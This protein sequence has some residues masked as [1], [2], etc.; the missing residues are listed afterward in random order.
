MKKIILIALFLSMGISS[1]AT[2]IIGGE[3]SYKCLG[4]NLY[5]YT[6]KI[7][8]DCFNGVPPL[9]DPAYFTIFD[10][11]GNV[12]LNTPVTLL[13]DSILPVNSPSPCL[14]IPPT[15]C[16]QEGTYGFFATLPP[17]AGGYIVAYQRCCRNASIIN[18]VDPGNIGATYTAE[19]NDQ[20]LALCNNSAY[21]LNYPPIVICAG[22]PLVFD[23]SA[24]DAD[25]DVLVYELCRPLMGAEPPANS[26][27]VIAAAPPYTGIPYQA[28]YT[29]ANPMDGLPPLAINANTGLLTITPTAL[30]QFVVG[31]CVKEY[32]GGVYLG[33]H[34][35]DF[36]FNVVNCT[37]TVVS[38]FPSIINNCTGFSFNFQNFSS[39]NISSYHWDFGVPSLT[40]DTSNLQFPFYTY[41]DTGVYTVTLEV[42]S[43]SGCA[44]TQTAQVYVYPNLNAGAIA[45][46]G[47]T[48]TPLQFSDASI[49]TF[50][51][52]NWWAWTF[53]DGG[54]SSEQNPTH[55]YTN[56]GTYA[57]QLI[58]HT[59]NGCADTAYQ[60]VIIFTSAVVGISPKDTTIIYG[61][62]T[63]LNATVNGGSTYAWFPVE[64]LSDPFIMNPVASPSVTT[65]YYLTVTSPEGCIT[66]DSAVVQ[67]VFVP[68]VKIP[69]A[70]SPNEDG[71]NDLFRP[72]IV[73]AITDAV[74]RI[75]NR[76][77]QLIYESHNGASGGWDGKFKSEPQEVGVYVYTFEC[78]GA[79]TGTQY[80]YK[81]NVTLLR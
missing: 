21:F 47:C 44:D 49:S 77:G 39:G 19:L 72:I 59:A 64:G 73:G 7:Y 37:P 3:I 67:I 13:V 56:P 32:R 48:N 66:V 46:D 57:I 55:S 15:I 54:T 52:I 18:I 70:F 75:Y 58:V 34:T 41:T 4:G 10:T 2:H 27:P 80:S 33:M 60:S 23:H 61:T 6:V 42:Y 5:E 31:V 40:N 12:I 68:L 17:I 28:P 79:G 8:R 43:A 22:M 71:S 69:N 20:V 11:S 9:D 29:A 1:F 53:G 51:D 25:G 38:S 78:K 76:W 63:I 14:S 16:V 45:P 26:Q 36:Q 81:G 74:F 62:S 50:G 30:G 35:R 65:T 24:V